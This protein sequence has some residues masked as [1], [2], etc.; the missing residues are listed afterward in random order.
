M[1]LAFGTAQAQELFIY[2]QEGQSKD[3]QEQDQ[4]QC[5]SWAK[6]ET[7]F[8]PMAPPTATEPPPQQEAKKGGAGRGAMRGAT[9]GVLVGDSSESAKKGAATGAAMGTMRRRDQQRQQQA[10]Q[11]NW[12]QEQSQIYA[13]K[14]NHYNRAYAACLE[15]RGYTVK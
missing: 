1:L 11:Q 9:V 12:E 8:D 10:Q 4:Y 14:R 7:G 15:G 2:P 3:Q 5:Y 13:E 6:D